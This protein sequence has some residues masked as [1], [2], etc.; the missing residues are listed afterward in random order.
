MFFSPVGITFVIITPP[1]NHLLITKHSAA[2]NEMNL[3]RY[4]RSPSV[5]QPSSSSVEATGRI[6]HWLQVSSVTP[7]RKVLFQVSVAPP[8]GHAKTVLLQHFHICTW[9]EINMKQ[10]WWIISCESCI[11]GAFLLEDYVT[12]LEIIAGSLSA[13]LCCILTASY[14][15]MSYWGLLWCRFYFLFAN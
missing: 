6:I 9:N 11:C 7:S 15:R 8:R 2:S 1:H 5:C 10:S 13:L 12:S 4:L 3:F 14:W